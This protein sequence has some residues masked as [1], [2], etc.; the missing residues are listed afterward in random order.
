MYYA[1][2]MQWGNQIKLWTDVSRRPIETAQYKNCVLLSHKR[3]R[4]FEN[5][6]NPYKKD[7]IRLGYDVVENKI[8]E[9]FWRQQPRR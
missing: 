9:I 6:K 8:P 1:L 5:I 2:Y 3:E 4:R 7:L